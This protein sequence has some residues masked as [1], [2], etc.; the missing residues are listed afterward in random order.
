MIYSFDVFDTLVTRRVLS[1]ADVFL[2]QADELIR[3][4]LWTATEADWQRTRMEAEAHVRTQRRGGEVTLE[5][6][7]E[8]LRRRCGLSNIA[9]AR[10]YDLETKL[11][12]E[13]AVLIEPNCRELKALEAGGERVVLA[14]D[15]YLPRTCMQEI[16]KCAELAHL[17]LYLSCEHGTTKSSGGLF[18]ILAST[19]NAL[20]PHV[21][22]RGDNAISDYKVPRRLGMSAEHYRAPRPT[23]A[24]SSMHRS[25]HVENVKLRALLAGAMRTARLA[26]P[27]AERTR[28]HAVWETATNTVGPLVVGFVLWVLAQ[29]QERGLKRVYFVARDGQIAWKVAR[30]LCMQ[31]NIAIECRYLHGSRQAWHFPATTRLDE[32]AWSWIFQAGAGLSLRSILER[33][34]IT[35]SELQQAATHLAIEPDTSLGASELERVRSYLQSIE[36]R[37]L[38]RAREKRA[39]IRDYFV[40][41]GFGD[42]T[43]YGIVDIGWKGRLQR[44][45]STILAASDLYPER[46]VQG[47]YVGLVGET[48]RFRR[49]TLHG[50]LFSSDVSASHLEPGHLGLYELMFSADHPGVTG[51]ERQPDGRIDASFRKTYALLDCGWPLSAQHEGVMRF[52]RDFALCAAPYA[53]CIPD[54]GAAIALNLQRFFATPTASEADAYGSARFSQEQTEHNFR[55]LA[56]ALTVVQLLRLL[57]RR[58][59]QRYA[60]TLWLEGSIRRTPGALR[61]LLLAMLA[62]R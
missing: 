15:M 19:E 44:S 58:A 48:L 13:M 21:S 17:P 32:H 41:E 62:R 50:F 49:D 37:I 1:P 30:H 5:L 60:S 52:A 11:E 42:G 20:L 16:L 34:A 6:I 4:G 12:A 55:E 46:G 3:H 9:A 29:A 59:E 23:Y 40:Q 27:F 24:E 14:S 7:Y 43:P 54:L 28:P 51:F 18:K 47:F 8:E 31:W 26:S 25:P 35:P 22:H 61:S 10:A 39:L 45:L 53:Q 57:S 2:F 33:L 38:E 36:A 56:P